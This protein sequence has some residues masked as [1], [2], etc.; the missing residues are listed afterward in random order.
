MIGLAAAPRP[1]DAVHA[2]AL[3]ADHVKAELLPLVT[4]ARA[5]REAH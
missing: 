3:L 1:P 2:E 5:R 4:E